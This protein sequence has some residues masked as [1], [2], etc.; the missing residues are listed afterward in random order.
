MRKRGHHRERG[1][2]MVE[3][4]IVIPVM[5]VFIGLIMWVHKSYSVKLDKQFGTRSQVLYYASHD[6]EG[7][8]GA[9]KTETNGDDPGNANGGGGGDP[10]APAGKMDP[11][12][13]AGVSRSWNLAKAKPA[14]TD[15]DG[16]AID[17]RKPVF[18]SRKISAG[19]EVACNEKRYDSSWKGVLGSIGSFA[20][21]GGGFIN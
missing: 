21:S 15:V 1:A 12:T 3:A 18:L 11:K 13:S 2:A 16:R 19:S 8:P 7:D 10:L 14:D 6:C 4:A 9:L 20:K 17:D 5:L